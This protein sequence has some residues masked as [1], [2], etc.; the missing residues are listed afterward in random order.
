MFTRS[1]Y[2]GTK[3]HPILPKD[4]LQIF[5]TFPEEISAGTILWLLKSSR[6]NYPRRYY[7][8]PKALAKSAGNYFPA[9]IST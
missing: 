6:N 1:T 9:E 5:F 2:T 3:A 8:E 7:L 4:F